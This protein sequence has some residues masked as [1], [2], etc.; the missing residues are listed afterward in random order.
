MGWDLKT[1]S[2]TPGTA[3]RHKGQYP[4][5]PF[6]LLLL[7]PLSGVSGKPILDWTP[8]ILCSELFKFVLITSGRKL[9][10]GR[11]QFF[12]GLENQAVRDSRFF[13]VWKIGIWETTGFDDETK[14]ATTFGFVAKL[15]YK[16]Y[17][18]LWEV[19]TSLRNYVQAV[20]NN[21]FG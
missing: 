19:L 13:V 7:L 3:L 1:A 2:E 14:W 18:C 15:I 11:L 5:K 16:G 10:Y 9:T 21:K 17:I 4:W 12:H 20:R 6:C 8:L